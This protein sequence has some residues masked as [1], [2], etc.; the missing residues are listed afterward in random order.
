[1]RLEFLTMENYRLFSKL[2]VIFHENLTVLAGNN[3]AGKTAVLEG[4]T[5]ALGTLFSKLDGI[6]GTSLRPS[7]ARLKAYAIGSSDDV[8]PQYPVRVT[9]VGL[10][11]GKAVQWT[12][13]LNTS[14]GSMTVGEAK[15]VIAFSQN[16][17]E[18]LRSGDQSL[19]LP[20]IAYYGTARLQD[21]HRE[22]R[23]KTRQKNTSTANHCE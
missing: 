2:N 1:M 15:E 19:L 17:Q 3:G 7:D 9:A 21:N 10:L 18:R 23:A 8:Q 11:D 12:R 13:G 5:V 4:A 22:K 6:T 14:E 20:L 16:W